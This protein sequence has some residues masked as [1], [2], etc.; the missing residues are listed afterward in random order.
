MGKFAIFLIVVCIACS[1]P[2]TNIDF[3]EIQKLIPVLTSL[4]F[5]KIYVRPN[6]L[7][8]DDFLV[9]SIDSSGHQKDS[10]G[11]LVKG[12]E[13]FSRIHSVLA[14]NG[15]SRVYFEN[16]VFFFVDGGWIDS[17]WGLAYSERNLIG[18]ESDF[19]F[20]RVQELEVIGLDSNWYYFYAD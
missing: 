16:D 11:N 6:E 7:F 18:T 3:S 17:Q 5:K 4:S 2:N 12:K 10:D 19:N 15:V 1:K 20:D 13:S 14:K 8:L 9:M